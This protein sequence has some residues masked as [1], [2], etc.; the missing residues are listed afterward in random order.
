MRA[1]IVFVMNHWIRSILLAT[2]V[3]VVGLIVR[4]AVRDSRK[5]ADEKRVHDANMESIRFQIVECFAAHGIEFKWEW[6]A[7]QWEGKTQVFPSGGYIRIS[8]VRSHEEVWVGLEQRRGRSDVHNV[9]ARVVDDNLFFRNHKLLRFQEVGVGKVVARYVAAIHNYE[10]IASD[11]R[12][13]SLAMKLGAEDQRHA[14]EGHSLLGEATLV[15]QS[16]LPTE[17]PHEEAQTA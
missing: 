8:E 16:H 4:K 13:Q 10:A 17:A 1:M 11:D 3:S 2:L 7:F 12:I 14:S 6:L 9:I 5:K 15:A